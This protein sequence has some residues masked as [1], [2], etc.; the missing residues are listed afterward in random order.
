M[1]TAVRNAKTPIFFFQAENDFDLSPTRVLSAAMQEAGK[2]S[3]MKIYPA[4]GT[5]ARDGHSFA[6]RGV[7]VWG[8]DVVRFIE[9]ACG[10][11]VPLFHAGGNAAYER[12]STCSCAK[13]IPSSRSGRAP[14]PT[15][16]HCPRIRNAFFFPV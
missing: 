10:P 4:F 8:D 16:A 3:E 6:Y 9:Q 2:R 5:T 13:P 12:S 11:S 7:A 1:T 15:S 14:R